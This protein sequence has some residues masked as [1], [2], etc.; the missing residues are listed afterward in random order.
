MITENKQNE[1]SL[2]QDLNPSFVGESGSSVFVSLDSACFVRE[3]AF[4]QKAL[5]V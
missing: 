1:K 3:E 2:L 5:W 4:C